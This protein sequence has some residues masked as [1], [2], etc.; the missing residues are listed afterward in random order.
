MPRDDD[1]R[2][3]RAHEVLATAARDHAR[4]VAA[5]YKQLRSDG[6]DTDEALDLAKDFARAL[7]GEIIGRDM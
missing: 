1:L 3:T 5:Y 7:F 4:S 2:I 6:I